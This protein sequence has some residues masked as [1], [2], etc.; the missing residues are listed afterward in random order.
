MDARG[1]QI[2]HLVKL[3]A[4]SRAKF[5]SDLGPIILVAASLMDKP[6]TQKIS[7]SLDIAHALVIRE[8]VHMAQDLGLI[9]I[10]DRNEKTSRLTLNLTHAGKAIFQGA[11]GK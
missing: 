8:C 5:N 4:E 3:A 7:R 11:T 6:D 10:V 9:D 2:P 1:G